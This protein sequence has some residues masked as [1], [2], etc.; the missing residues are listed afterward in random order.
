MLTTAPR[1]TSVNKLLERREHT[2]MLSRLMEF[3]FN[4]GTALVI[5]ILLSPFLLVVAVALLM[6]DGSP[7]TFGHYRVGKNGKLFKCLKF[8]TMVRDSAARLEALL[9]S[10]AEARAEWERDHKLTNDPRITPIGN[11]LRRTSLDELPQLFNV[12]RGE[13]NLVGPRPVTVPELTKYG[14]VKRHYLSVM[15]GI[16]GLWQVSGRND[17]TYDERVELDRHYVE[18]KN[19]ATDVKLLFM[20]VWVVLARKGAK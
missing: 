3:V 18:H 8:R 12:L 20:T 6:S 17:L 19:F 14:H 13:M 7:L 4:R 15:P 16:T 5:L 2:G 1:A 9:A 10:S 11:F